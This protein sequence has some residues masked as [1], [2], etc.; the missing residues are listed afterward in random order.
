MQI[1]TLFKKHLILK[2]II[3]MLFGALLIALLADTGL[4]PQVLL[5]SPQINSV[6]P[7]PFVTLLNE[8]DRAA[9][10]AW[11]PDGTQLAASSDNGEPHIWNVSDRTLMFELSGHT[12]QVKSIAWSP[13][14]KKLATVSWDGTVRIWDSNTG[15][16]REIL[17]ADNEALDIVKWSSDGSRLAN[18]GAGSIQIWDSL[19]FELLGE[20]S[21]AKRRAALSADATEIAVAYTDGTVEVQNLSDILG[22]ASM[23]DEYS[24]VA[25][26]PDMSQL[27]TVSADNH[28][29]IWDVNTEES[30]AILEGCDTEIISLSWRPNG[31]GLAAV[32]VDI[33]FSQNEHESSIIIWELDINSVVSTLNVQEYKQ[34][35]SS[36]D[37]LIWSPNGT[38]LAG[39]GGNPEDIDSIVWIWDTTTG[40]LLST[41]EHP[42]S[43]DAIAWNPDGSMLATSS[44]N[45][46]RIWRSSDLS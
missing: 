21:S 16:E 28:I 41:L 37:E 27:A 5:L 3:I 33:Y 34:I 36:N 8:T 26:S 43:V 32:C 10:I 1:A 2:V 38:T 25:W 7:Y 19:D 39:L 9:T 6:S 17:Q 30:T 24:L 11:S 45:W 13:D 35:R 14:G 42:A 44:F 46:I 29:H 20:F 12:D 18:L 31:H 15:D 22:I 4:Q 23:L 40:L